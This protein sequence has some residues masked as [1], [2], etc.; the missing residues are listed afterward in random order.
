MLAGIGMPSYLGGNQPL[1]GV[2]NEPAAAAPLPG[3][4]TR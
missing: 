4:L 1:S 2:P 3:T